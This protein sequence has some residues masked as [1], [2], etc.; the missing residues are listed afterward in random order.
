M[1]KTAAGRE[2]MWRWDPHS[3]VIPGWQTRHTRTRA[4]CIGSLCAKATEVDVGTQICGSSK[5]G[6]MSHML[7]SFEHSTLEM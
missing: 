2:L 4:R 7:L 1:K 5:K 6:L 3:Q